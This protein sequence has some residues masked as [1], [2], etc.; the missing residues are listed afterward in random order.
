MEMDNFAKL[1]LVESDLIWMVLGFLISADTNEDDESRKRNIE[2][3]LSLR[4]S[5]E[6]IPE[7]ERRAKILKYIDD[8]VEILNREL[9]EETQA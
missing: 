1:K 4:E 5:V 2:S 8:G 7:S 6:G 3:L 9:G